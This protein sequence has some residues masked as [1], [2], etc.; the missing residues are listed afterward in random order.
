[1]ED[2]SWVFDVSAFVRIKGAGKDMH[3][4]IMCLFELVGNARQVRDRDGNIT[5]EPVRRPWVIVAA[6]S[7]EQTHK[8]SGYFRLRATDEL[9][10]GFGIDFGTAVTFT[11]AGGGWESGTWSPGRIGGQRPA[12]EPVIALG[13]TVDSNSGNDMWVGMARGAAKDE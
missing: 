9:I 8:L 13:I 12:F 7:L 3:Q 2:L 4:A 1:P 11:A 6:T 10:D 5:V